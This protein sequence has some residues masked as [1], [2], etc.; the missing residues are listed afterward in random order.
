MCARVYLPQESSEGALK[1]AMFQILQCTN[2]GKYIHL[3]AQRCQNYVLHQK[4]LQ[5]KIVKVQF[6]TKNSVILDVYL[7]QEWR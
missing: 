7:L 6:P 4:T 2:M 1:T 5:M 3:R